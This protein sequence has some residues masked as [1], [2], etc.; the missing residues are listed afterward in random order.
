MVQ[1]RVHR[2]LSNVAPSVIMN[3]DEDL[4]D[5]PFFMGLK[6]QFATQYSEVE[7][8]CHVVLVPS[9]DSLNG[10]DI[11]QAL[12]GTP[13]RYFL[14]LLI[15]LYTLKETQNRCKWNSDF[16][17]AILSLFLPF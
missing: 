14:M 6:K 15:C 4:F 11:T 2:G 7:T 13:H 10:V 12:I 9:A 5:N 16:F 1:L 3:D 17:F 8:G